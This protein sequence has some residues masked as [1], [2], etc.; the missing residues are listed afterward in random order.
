MTSSKISKGSFCSTILLLSIFDI[1]S[2]SLISIS[3][4]LEEK[5]ILE[6]QS[7]ALAGSSSEAAAIAV[8]LMMAFKGVRISWLIRDRKSLFAMLARSAVSMASCSA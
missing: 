3:R 4:C 2:T 8:I 6:R 5:V 7:S 1:S